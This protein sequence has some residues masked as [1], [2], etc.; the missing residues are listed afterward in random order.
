MPPHDILYGGVCVKGSRSGRRTVF[1]DHGD[2]DVYRF[3]PPFFS[4][5]FERMNGGWVNL[6]SVFVGERDCFLRLF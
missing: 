1:D 6:A 3:I 2:D 5:S 4:P